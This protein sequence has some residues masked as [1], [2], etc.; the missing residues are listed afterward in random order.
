[1]GD[2]GMVLSLQSLSHVEDRNLLSG[3][4]AMYLEDFNLAQ[5]LFLSSSNPSAALEVHPRFSIEDA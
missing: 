5:D 2:A 4:V 3:Y 1:M